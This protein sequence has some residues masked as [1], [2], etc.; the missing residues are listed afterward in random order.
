MGGKQN[1]GFAYKKGLAVEELADVTSLDVSGDGSLR[2]GAL[3]RITHNGR[4]FKM[5]SVHLKSG[6]FDD[7]FAG[8]SCTRLFNQVPKLEA[9]IDTEAAG[10]EP[11]IVLGDFNRRFINPAIIEVIIQ[12]G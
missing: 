1:T 5:L 6:C 8:N 10:N 7:S 11:F 12:A 3:I 4:S 2:Y 9:W